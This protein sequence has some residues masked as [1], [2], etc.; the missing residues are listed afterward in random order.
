MTCDGTFLEQR[1]YTFT[2]KLHRRK[3]TKTMCVP[4]ISL[5]SA[6]KTTVPVNVGSQFQEAMVGARVL[7]LAAGPG[8]GWHALGTGFQKSTL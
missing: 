3:I 1:R 6:G 2:R 7:P 5:I 8:H 4:V